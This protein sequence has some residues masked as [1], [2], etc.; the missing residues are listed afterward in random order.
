MLNQV[1]AMKGYNVVM[2]MLLVHLCNMYENVCLQ[3][4]LNLILRDTIAA[5]Y[6]KVH[7]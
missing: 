7:I 4:L 2:T 5:D 6:F 3:L 1:F